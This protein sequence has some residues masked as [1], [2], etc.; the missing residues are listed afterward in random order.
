MVSNSGSV[1]D[2]SH[3]NYGEHL[4]IEQVNALTR[5]SDET[6]DLVHEWLEDNGISRESCKYS[7]AKDWISVSLPIGQVE[8]LLDTEY[9]VYKHADGSYLVRTPQWSL[10]LHLHDHIETIQPTNSFLRG[11]KQAYGYHQDMAEKRAVHHKIVPEAPAATYTPSQAP[12]ACNTSNVTP[13]CLRAFY[14][15]DTYK[16]QSAGKNKIGLTDYLMESNNRSDTFR[17]LS[18]YRPEAAGAAYQF[19]VEVIAGGNDEQTQETPEELDA[20]KDLEGN[21]DVETIISE[22]W[23]TPLIAYTTGGSPPFKPDN[24]TPTNTNEPYLVWVEYVLG[25]RDVP[26]AISTS[27]G[28]DERK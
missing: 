20:G 10:P 9:Q 14:G 19:K 17:F 13:A 25:Q 8:Q 7:S 24:S 6:S 15:T 16:V 18:Q 5:P 4:S 26:Q 2:P 21:L 12:A 1:S 3:P 27:Y 11:A 23:P 28:D 22:T